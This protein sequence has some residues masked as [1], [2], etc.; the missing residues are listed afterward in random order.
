VSERVS[1]EQRAREYGLE[2]GENNIRKEE[3]TEAA[4]LAG[5]RAA[6]EDAARACEARAKSLREQTAYPEYDYEAEASVLEQQAAAILSL[7][8]GR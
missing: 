6:L 2:H 5:Y 3:L 1:L 4:Y 7:E 8:D